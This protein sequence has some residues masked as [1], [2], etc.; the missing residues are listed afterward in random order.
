[1]LKYLSILIL[2]LITQECVFAQEYVVNWQKSYGGERNEVA[3]AGVETSDGGFILVGS[4][5]SK[6]SFD[7]KDS[8]GFDGTGGNDFWISKVSNTGAIVWAKT[9]GGS[10]DDVATSIV[11]TLNNEYLILGTSQSTDGDAIFNGVNGG[12][13]LIRLKENGDFVS[14]RLFAGGNSNSGVSFQQVN[15]FSKPTIKILAD[16]QFIVGATRSIGVNPFSGYDFYV[17]K[18]STFGDTLWEKTFGGGLEDYMNDIIQTSDG[19]YLMVGG[20][21]SLERDITGAGQGFLDML[22]IKIDGTGRQLWEKGFGGNNY[23]VAFSALENSSKTGFY[24]AGESS[25]ING[26]IGNSLGEKDGII[27]RIDKNGIL[28]NKNHFGGIENDGFYSLI[29]GTDGVLYASG[30]S[31][32]T[33]GTTKPKGTLTDVWLMA[34]KEETFVPIFHKLFG[35][36]DIDLARQ[37]IYS[38]K[39]GLFLAASSRS[40]D[41]DA[42]VNRGQSDFWAL[43]LSLPPPII[44]GK[45]QAFLN[46]RQEI[47]LVW[48]TTFEQNSQFIFIEK[49]DDNKAF[50][51]KDEQAAVG[52]STGIVSYRFI[53]KNPIFGNN[54]YRLRYTDLANKS[55]VGPTVS[56]NFLPLSILNLPIDQFRVYPNPATDFVLIDTFLENP[57]IQLVDAKGISVPF[58]LIKIGDSS[59]K[60]ILANN[61]SIGIYHVVVS[62][63]VAKQTKKIIVN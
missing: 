34:L 56:F 11:K 30:T 25:S 57:T 7:V 60:I 4:T 23:D 46:E 8:K 59:Y 27:L 21:L 18:L 1:M 14:K 29:R 36:A 47:E 33:I 35:G 5:N 62:N 42:S 3:Y 24:I 20:T 61:P 2:I 48:T 26:Q 19:G 58:E 39:N 12:L 9:F 53:D 28:Q 6:N 16:G 17:A 22:V 41:G 10:K 31:Q 44:F 45:F 50:F 38:S 37:V 43:N 54:Y 13:I 49:S 32:S 40:A 52:V 51:Q 63:S 55:Y 15:S